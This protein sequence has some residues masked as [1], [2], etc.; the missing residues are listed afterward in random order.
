METKVE[1]TPLGEGVEELDVDGSVPGTDHTLDH[2][3]GYDPDLLTNEGAL[4]AD[5]A[6]V[7]AS[8]HARP[9]TQK[10]AGDDVV[11]TAGP[12]PS[13]A[14]TT[15]PSTA[16]TTAP[17][18]NTAEA[19]PVDMSLQGNKAEKAT[20]R[21]AYNDLMG[22]KE[23]YD[24]WSL[25]NI[26]GSACGLGDLVKGVMS[27]V[28]AYRIHQE[29]QKGGPNADNPELKQARWDALK[30]GAERIFTGL[31][32]IGVILGA[33]AGSPF[34]IALLPV[35]MSMT[36]GLNVD[37]QEGITGTNKAIGEATANNLL[38][39][40][41]T[42]VASVADIQRLLRDPNDPSLANDPSIPRNPDGTPIENEFR[43]KLREHFEAQARGLVPQAQTN[44]GTA[45]DWT[46][47]LGGNGTGKADAKAALDGRVEGIA[48]AFIK[49]IKDGEFA[50][51]PR[52][53]EEKERLRDRLIAEIAQIQHDAYNHVVQNP[54]PAPQPVTPAPANP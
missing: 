29:I 32:T 6:T 2:D 16:P 45:E 50:D 52:T 43:K 9:H 13:A 31:A 33:T 34:A 25:R 46:R 4:T 26:V 47:W 49:I 35:A 17:G 15:A 41:K 14:P 28:D 19:D 54:N 20:G 12:P 48:D 44:L 5:D 53:A 37:H 38:T 8:R 22:N 18:L 10:P 39:E 11:L 21:D 30:E 36:F 24:A 23:K 42:S 1:T 40:T 51:R 7:D 27:L 3:G